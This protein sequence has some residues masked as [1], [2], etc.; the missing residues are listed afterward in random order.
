[1]LEWEEMLRS[2]ALL[3]APSP[4]ML[5]ELFLSH[6]VRA[7]RDSTCTPDALK[8]LHLCI[9][10]RVREMARSQILS[11]CRVSSPMTLHYL[12]TQ[13]GGRARDD[14]QRSQALAPAGSRR[15]G[16]ASRCGAHRRLRTQRELAANVTTAEHRQQA[17][18]QK[19]GHL[20]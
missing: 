3:S 5:A 13:F 19:E 7:L 2:I 18:A 15:M 8:R 20:P 12:M 16:I 11:P 4:L 6:P 9:L 1:M 17:P 10:H 14:L